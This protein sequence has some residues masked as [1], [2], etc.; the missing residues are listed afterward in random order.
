MSAKLHIFK[1]ALDDL[2]DALD[3]YESQSN[4]LEIKFSKAIN[5][6]LSFIA[7]YPKASSIRL[8]GFRGA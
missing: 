8:E 2:Q 5:Q 7:K 4:G 1:D 3:W 6:R